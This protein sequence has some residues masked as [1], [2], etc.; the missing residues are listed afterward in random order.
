MIV[1]KETSDQLFDELS[2]FAKKQQADLAEVNNDRERQLQDIKVNLER[3]AA[4][5]KS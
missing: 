3:W 2:T 1:S 4:V 5:L